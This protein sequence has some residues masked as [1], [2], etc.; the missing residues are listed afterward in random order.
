MT[1]SELPAALARGEKLAGKDLRRGSKSFA[2]ASLFLPDRIRQDAAVCYA[3]CRY[4]DDAVD[5]VPPSQAAAAVVA[6]RALV[7][8][9]YQGKPQADPRLQAFAALIKRVRMPRD[10][11]MALVDGMA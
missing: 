2:L 10:Y 7:D 9:L 4:V 1:T 8:D 6:L 5:E 11:P 3:F